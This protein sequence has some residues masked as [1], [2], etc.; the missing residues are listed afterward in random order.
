VP[1]ST[2]IR[3]IREK[4][5]QD[6]LL[7]PSVTALIFDD[8]GRVLLQRSS[9][10][11]KWHTVGGA[12]DPGE[13]PA[14]AAVREVK[15]ETDLDVEVVQLTG[16]YAWPESRYSN[17]DICH[18]IAIAYRCRVVSGT[19]RVADDESLELKYFSLDELPQLLDV[20]LQVIADAAKAAKRS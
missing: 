20:E 2:Y 9:D 19:L 8:G 18:Y 16:A 5:G 14:S 11:G 7:L 13:E 4:I 1:A 15:E 3:K 10:D 6:P 12:I 17:G